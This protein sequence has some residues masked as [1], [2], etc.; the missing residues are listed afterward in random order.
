MASFQSTPSKFR[1]GQVLAKSQYENLKTSQFQSDIN[2]VA[3][4]AH[5]LAYIDCA[6][7]G[8]AVAVLPHASVGKNHVPLSSPAYAQPIIRAHAQRVEDF[9][10]DVFN[11]HRLYTC[12]ADQS[13]KVWRV[14]E[15]GLTVD[16]SVAEATLSECV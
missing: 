10:F 16:L 11:A 4:N 6:G 8:S 12:S 5:F 14:P 9:A 7:A 15:Q 13:V 3:A 2:G 1:D